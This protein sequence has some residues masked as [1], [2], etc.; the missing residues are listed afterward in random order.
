MIEIQ[1][2]TKKFGDF[3]VRE[4]VFVKAAVNLKGLPAERLPQIAFLG[5]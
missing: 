1:G 4:A 5:G 3:T 2:L